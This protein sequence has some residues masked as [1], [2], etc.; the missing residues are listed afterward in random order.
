MTQRGNLDPRPAGGIVESRALFGTVELASVDGRGVTPISGLRASGSRSRTLSTGVSATWPR[1]QIDV[2]RI[3]SSSC[4]AG[5]ARS[6]SLRTAVDQAHR[7]LGADAAGN[8][9]PAGLVAEERRQVAAEIEQ[10]G[11]CADDDDCARPREPCPPPATTLPVHG[12]V[13]AFGAGRKPVL[14]PPGRNAWT[15]E[16]SVAFRLTRATSSRSAGAERRLH[17]AGLGGR[18][19]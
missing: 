9:L 7:L 4:R 11:V 12:D 5:C 1:P 10:V 3:A 6:S 19:H 18:H 17:D 15:S 16:S 8:A 2:S 13:G 14:A